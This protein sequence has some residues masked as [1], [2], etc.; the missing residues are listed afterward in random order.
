M[1]SRLLNTEVNAKWEDILQK[2]LSTG[3][4]NQHAV[5]ANT[6]NG[7]KKVC[8]DWNNLRWVSSTIEVRLAFWLHKCLL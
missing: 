5:D 2:D 7:F 6:V 1:N 8:N 4:T 3:R